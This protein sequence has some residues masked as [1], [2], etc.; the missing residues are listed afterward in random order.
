MSEESDAGGR[1]DLP[2]VVVAK[3]RGVSLVWL[4]PV[5]ALAIGA[6]YAVGF[7]SSS[8]TYSHARAKSMRTMGRSSR[9]KL[10]VCLNCS[11]SL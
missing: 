4:V 2:E 9:V 6:L 11:P 10:L 3:G 5:V 8:S 7:G 1:E